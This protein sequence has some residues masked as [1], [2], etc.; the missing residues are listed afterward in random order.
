VKAVTG[1]LL[2]YNGRAAM[3]G[4]VLEDARIIIRDGRIEDVTGG[5]GRGAPPARPPRGDPGRAPPPGE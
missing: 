2:L 4:R 3:P 1:D 5:A